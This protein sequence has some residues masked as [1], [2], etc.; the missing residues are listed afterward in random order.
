MRSPELALSVVIMT[1]GAVARSLPEQ[2]L[3]INDKLNKITAKS[4]KTLLYLLKY[5][6][7]YA[8]IT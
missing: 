1:A 8:I 2:T 5:Y 7:K 4:V 6:S 3:K